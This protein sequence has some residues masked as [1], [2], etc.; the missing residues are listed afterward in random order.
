MVKEALPPEYFRKYMRLLCRFQICCPLSRNS[1]LVP[2][3]L[4][5][6]PRDEAQNENEEEMDSMII[7]YHTFAIPY[8]FW[9]RLISRLLLFLNELLTEAILSE[10]PLFD[11]ESSCET[12]FWNSRLSESNDGTPKGTRN[13]STCAGSMSTPQDAPFWSDGSSPSKH[14]S[15]GSD[16]I[17]YFNDVTRS[18]N[19][20]VFYSDNSNSTGN[21]C[22]S[23]Q[24]SSCFS[25]GSGGEFPSSSQMFG[26][27]IYGN[28]ATPATAGSSSLD[29]VTHCG[30]G[31]GYFT[32]TT[33][34]ESDDSDEGSEYEDDGFICIRPKRGDLPC[35]I[36][37]LN[38]SQT[39]F[40]VDTYEQGL[41]EDVKEVLHC[42]LDQVCMNEQLGSVHLYVNSNSDSCLNID[43]RESF[44][45][46]GMYRCE[47]ISS[48]IHHDDCSLH[49]DIYKCEQSIS[50]EI[51]NNNDKGYLCEDMDTCE[52]ALMN[53]THDVLC[54][55]IDSIEVSETSYSDS[56][57]RRST[58]ESSCT[59]R[60][61]DQKSFLKSCSS[62]DTLLDE[63]PSTLTQNSSKTPSILR[64][65]SSNTSS[66]SRQNS[67]KPNSIVN[68]IGYL[69]NKQILTC[70]KDG[71]TF[72]HPDLYFSI[73]ETDSI[74]PNRKRIVTKVCNTPDGFRVLTNIL[75][76]IRTLIKEWFSGLIGTDG[77]N[78][79]IIQEIPCPICFDFNI[80][81]PHL[82]D[83]RTVFERIWGG[84]NHGFNIVCRNRHIP[85]IV[86]V[87]LLCPELVF[88]DL[89]KSFHITKTELKYEELV[90]NVIGKGGFGTIYR[91][92]YR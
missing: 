55:I 87:R 52:Q 81:P 16:S 86:D 21:S 25:S 46:D 20:P 59:L 53:E 85:Q 22:G 66:L 40:I 82:F 71:I 44:K 24:N 32:S 91:G 56:E 69:I 76:H 28:A 9:P 48:E 63:G 7:R 80:N 74:R 61:K 57:S 64:Q 49:D 17:V 65:N 26:F 58:N 60:D 3:K 5:P 6:K 14:N 79:L 13:P 19:A 92:T 4:T 31:G 27:P 84:S 89:P 18:Q 70:W 83:I 45:C 50:E 8:G 41:I 43:G 34:H 11:D 51:R 62:H 1:F 15:S 37:Q 39:K 42:L 54:R 77:R 47:Q 75:D 23:L 68:N 38:T 2:S 88:E 10:I 67:K 35:V 30:G 90:D 73:Q 78:P 12:E 33:T 36:N 72:R 29:S